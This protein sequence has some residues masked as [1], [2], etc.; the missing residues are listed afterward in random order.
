MPGANDIVETRD[1]S[2]RLFLLAFS[3]TAV[4]MGYQ[5]TQIFPNFLTENDD[6][7]TAYERMH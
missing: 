3:G 2:R 6:L 5:T 7:W 4:D 1:E